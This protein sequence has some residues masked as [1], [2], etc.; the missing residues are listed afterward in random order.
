MKSQAVF[1]LEVILLE[2][3]ETQENQDCSWSKIKSVLRSLSLY[4]IFE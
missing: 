3:R 2:A 4:P 1:I